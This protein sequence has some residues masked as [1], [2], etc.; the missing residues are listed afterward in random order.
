MEP[1]ARP[2]LFRSL[3][4]RVG[5]WLAPRRYVARFRTGLHTCR[6]GGVALR[7]NFDHPLHRAIYLQDGFEPEMTRVLQGTLESGDLFVDIGGNLGWHTVSLMG[8][9]GDVAGCYTYEPSSANAA[10]IRES[11]EANGLEARCQVRQMAL[12]DVVGTIGLKSF[13]GLDSMHASLFPLA[14]LEYTEETVPQSTLDLEAA[15]YPAAPAVIKCDVEGAEMSVLRGAA[16][17]L[18]GRFG[19]PPV[20]FL[21]ANYETAAMAGY[22]PWQLLHT[23]AEYAPYRAYHIRDG[24]IVA[25]PHDKAL[26]HGDTLILAIEKIHARRLAQASAAG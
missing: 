8:R 4:S 25:L 3:R 6:V 2:G 7:L 20:W 9:R 5:R 11:L 14:D 15:T 17:L 10:L 22:F 23:A 12:G 19:P 13:K 1:A 18:R 16:E 24:R 26:R 21:E